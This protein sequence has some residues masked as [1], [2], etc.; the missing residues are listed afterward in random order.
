MLGT[1]EENKIH[2]IDTIQVSERAVGTDQ[3]NKGT[4]EEKTLRLVEI[5]AMKLKANKKK[6]GKKGKGK[7][8]KK[9]SK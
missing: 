7:K 8:K 3:I 5:L 9:K 4:E 1:E 2:W 6:K